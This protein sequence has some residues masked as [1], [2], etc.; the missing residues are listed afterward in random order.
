[1]VKVLILVICLIAFIPQ[2]K[3]NRKYLKSINED[4]NVFLSP[5]SDSPLGRYDSAAVSPESNSCATIATVPRIFWKKAEALRMRRL[6]DS[7]AREHFTDNSMGIGGGFLLVLYNATTHRS[8]VL[9]T[10]SSAP[11]CAHK[12]MFDE[13]SANAT[14]GVLHPR[15]NERLHGIAPCSRRTALETII[16]THNWPLRE[17]IQSDPDKSQ[18]VQWI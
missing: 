13:Y 12:H 16:W 4:V 14:T 11:S 5:P 15:W 6:E 3:C 18:R 1:M 7:S 10:R 9:N 2:S 17:W 8:K